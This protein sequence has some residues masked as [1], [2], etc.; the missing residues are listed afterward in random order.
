MTKL[1]KMICHRLPD[2]YTERNLNGKVSDTF[3]RVADDVILLK[4]N[5]EVIRNDVL[6]L[7]E[8]ITSNTATFLRVFKHKL[9]MNGKYPKFSHIK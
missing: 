6:T 7:K 3:Q 8:Q 5:D 9:K 1:R 2:S 4:D